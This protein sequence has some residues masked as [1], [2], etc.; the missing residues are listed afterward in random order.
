MRGGRS[1]GGRGARASCWARRRATARAVPPGALLPPSPRGAG[2]GPAEAPV[3]GGEG[4]ARERVRVGRRRR[5]RM[6]QAS[7]VLWAHRALQVCEASVADRHVG[8]SGD[9]DKPH[10]AGVRL[11][12]KCTGNVGV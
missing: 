6:A 9:G 1:A 5:G 4:R 10:S 11:A 8:T 2:G 12:T 7:T 3:I